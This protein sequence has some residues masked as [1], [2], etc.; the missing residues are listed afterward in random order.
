MRPTREAPADPDSADAALAAAL[1]ILGGASQSADALQRK[2]HQ[3]G[4]S[5]SA[6]RSAVER[7]REYGYVD[8]SALAESL[9]GRHVRAGHGRARVVAELRRRGVSSAAAAQAL[10]AVDEDDELR[11]ATEVAQKLYEREA[12][13]GDVDDRARRRIAA[14]LQRRGFASGV[15]LNA[16]RSVRV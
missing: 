12:R 9:V 10:D 2:L 1:R 11:S 15:I 6:V 13:R 7:C 16:L 8:D 4:Y 5:S 14:A 3:R